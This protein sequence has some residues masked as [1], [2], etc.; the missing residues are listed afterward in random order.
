MTLEQVSTI[1]NYV[2]RQIMPMFWLTMDKV[3]SD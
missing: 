3:C 1:M 2:Y